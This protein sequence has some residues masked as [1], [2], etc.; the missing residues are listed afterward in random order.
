MK[1]KL[2]SIAYDLE[3]FAFCF[4]ILYQKLLAK[5]QDVQQSGAILHKLRSKLSAKRFLF[6]MPRYTS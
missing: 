1:L 4:N 3:F 6:S 5:K 2:W